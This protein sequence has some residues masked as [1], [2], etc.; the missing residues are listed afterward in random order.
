M[1]EELITIISV[2]YNT[3]DF[4]EVQLDAFTKLTKNKFK[5]LIADNGSNDKNLLYLSQMLPKF[6]NVWV[7]FRKQ[8]AAGSVGHAEALDFLISKVETPYFLVMDADAVILKKN[9]DVELIKYIDRDTKAIGAPPIKGSPKA[10]DFPFSYI[11]FLETE[12]YKKLNCSFMP[13]PGM[14]AQG[15]DTGF[16]IREYFFKN[17]LKVLCFDDHNT[18][19]DKNGPYR[20]IL[21]AEYYWK[22]DQENILACHFARGSSDGVTK[23]KYHWY[24]QIPLLSSVLKKYLGKRDRKKW[25]SKTYELISS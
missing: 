2:N 20:D 11:V 6:K 12:T 24:Y 9:W 21:C 23:Y 25:I 7:Y 13:I 1:N 18:R 14:E 17:N 4:L 22:W 8:S 10:Q 16:L 5:V 3:S 19:H 15:K